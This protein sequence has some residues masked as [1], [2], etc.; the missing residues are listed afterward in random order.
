M[1]PHALY[2]LPA[3][4][5]AISGARAQSGTTTSLEPLSSKTFTWPNIPYQVT[6]DD[7]GPRGPQVGYNLCNSTTENQ[8]SLCQ[9][10]NDACLS[11][12]IPH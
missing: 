4:A 11:A 10:S 6:G 9:V 3:L 7:G 1:S 8:D 5:F 12:Q 2:L